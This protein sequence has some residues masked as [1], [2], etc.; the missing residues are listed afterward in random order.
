MPWISI[1]LDVYDSTLSFS[2]LWWILILLIVCYI[3]TC[4]LGGR[5]MECVW[6]V[7]MYNRWGCEVTAFSR[8]GSK[9]AEA[10]SFGADHF[11]VTADEAAVAAAVNSVDVILMTAGG[12][13]VDWGMLFSFLTMRGHIYCM[14]ITG[15]AIP[16]PPVPLIT[17]EKGIS[18][19][20][21]GSRSETRQ[22]LNFAAKHSIVPQVEL[23]PAEQ[24]NEVFEKMGQGTVRYRAVLDFHADTSS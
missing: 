10:R 20:L 8:S 7:G 13:G 4:I 19:I 5:G 23:F 16:V 1:Y 12:P 11:V 24:V 15:A 21:V 9:E 14:G 18:G 22:M 2:R 17:Q 6:N 3:A